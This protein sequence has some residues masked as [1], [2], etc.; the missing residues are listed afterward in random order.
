MKH[1]EEGFP[2]GSVV[3]RPPANVKRHRSDP[4]SGRIPLGMEQLSR[5]TTVESVLQSQ[6]AA[7][8]EARVPDSPCSTARESPLLPATREKFAL[9]QRP[10]TAKIHKE[11]YFKI[12]KKYIYG[13]WNLIFIEYSCILK[14]HSSGF[15]Q[16]FIKG[17]PCGSDGKEAACNA[18]GPGL[19]PGSGR[20][21]GEG[22]GNPLQY[23]GLE[24]STDGGAWWA[25]VHGVTESDMTGDLHNL[26][27]H[28]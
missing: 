11:N 26:S 22:N 9:Q 20:S 15:L 21:T 16:L 17:F 5:A 4:W 10:S 8:S 19:T 28:S 18:W 14:Q 1:I 27:N 24:N 6:R 25:I 23:S 12:N 13:H 7:T 2:H 3:N